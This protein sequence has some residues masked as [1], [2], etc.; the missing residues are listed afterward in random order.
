[1]SD[2]FNEDEF[3]ILPASDSPAPD[4]LATSSVDRPE[5]NVVTE[6]GFVI[7]PSTPDFVENERAR[8]GEL[9]AAAA[10]S[11]EKTTTDVDVGDD[12]LTASD[13]LDDSGP[14]IR[15]SDLV[16][17]KARIALGGSDFSVL[18]GVDGKTSYEM[19]A[20][21][22]RQQTDELLMY[23]SA[24]SLVEELLEAMTLACDCGD[25]DDCA[26]LAERR[27]GEKA[28]EWRDVADYSLLNWAFYAI[29]LTS[30]TRNYDVD[31]LFW[32][33]NRRWDTETGD[34]IA[35]R[36][37]AYLKPPTLIA[38]AAQTLVARIAEAS[39]ECA[40]RRANY[41]SRRL[42]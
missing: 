13:D 10:A 15:L 8:D 35:P 3:V 42:G 4:S 23:K 1:M 32:L 9:E 38:E 2:A 25:C 33:A 30:S 40:R 39:D 18:I 22:M 17:R 14:Q 5:E 28:I 16:D 7:L 37:A 11:E 24:L 27:S 31:R 34:I 19:D 20:V 6:A 29:E 41:A 26:L 12:V 36:L 21:A